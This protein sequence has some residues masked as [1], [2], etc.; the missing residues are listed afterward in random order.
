VSSASA[1]SGHRLL[2]EAAQENIKKWAFDSGREYDVE[3][4]YQFKLEKPDVNFPPKVRI[5]FDLPNRV[6]IVANF[7]KLNT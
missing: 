3:I 4:L 6:V 1:S 5:T 7:P 2:Q